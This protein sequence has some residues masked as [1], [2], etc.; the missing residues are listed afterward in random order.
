MLYRISIM[1]IIGVALL[2]ASADARGSRGG[3]H[4]GGG[5]HYSHGYVNK[6]G[7]YVSGGLRHYPKAKKHR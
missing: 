6:H 1:T 7:H 2:T 3:S 4:H 5:Y